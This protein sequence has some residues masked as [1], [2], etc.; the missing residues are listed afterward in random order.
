VEVPARIPLLTEREHLTS[1]DIYVGMVLELSFGVAP[2]EL[3]SAIGAL[4]RRHPLLAASLTD[5]NQVPEV[6]YRWGV[7][8]PIV[9]SH[10]D[11]GWTEWMDRQAGIEFDLVHGPLLRVN[12]R[13]IDGG[14]EIA[15]LGHHLLGDGRAFWFLARDLVAAL[16][17]TLDDAVLAPQVIAGQECFPKGARLRPV[18]RLLATALNRAYRRDAHRPCL[19]SPFIEQGDEAAAFA[20]GCW[21][22]RWA[23]TQLFQRFREERRPGMYVNAL[24][25][26]DTD[27]LVAACRAHSVTVTEAV[28][29]A[30]LATRPGRPEGSDKVGVS[31]DLRPLVT[32]SPGE[33][34]GNFVGGVSVHMGYDEGRT[35]WENVGAVAAALRAKLAS[36]RDRCIAPAFIAALDPD[37]LDAM[38]FAAFA[39]LQDKTANRLASILCGSPPDRGLAVS[40]LG[41]LDGGSPRIAE[42]HFVPPL[43]ASADFVVGVA[44]FAGRLEFTLRYSTREHSVS[45]V[46]GA[47][48]DAIGLLMGV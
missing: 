16:G 31:C 1:P 41:V 12:A 26:D 22:R 32:P 21:G 25:A 10:D 11:V 28:T 48:A 36:P 24:S 35:F 40:S 45:V 4:V 8:L 7:C 17:G 34:L 23:Y 2:D 3:E 27:V 33:G 37:L 14:T 5:Y 46:E 13:R 47:C 15:L 6:A 20:R 39:G 43:F 30:F 9:P 42:M 38:N 19:E 44:T 29:T 18:A